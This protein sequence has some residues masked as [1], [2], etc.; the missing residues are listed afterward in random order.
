[1]ETRNF[2]YTDVNVNGPETIARICKEMGVQRLVHMSSINARYVKR[3]FLYTLKTVQHSAEIDLR[4]IKC[5]ITDIPPIYVS[6]GVNVRYFMFF[7]QLSKCYN[8]HE[9]VTY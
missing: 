4:N 3:I 7:L 6:H 2:S 9:G 5:L 1:M 8:T